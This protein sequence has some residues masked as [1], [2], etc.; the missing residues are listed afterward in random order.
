MRREDPIGAAF[1]NVERLASR[2]RQDWIHLRIRRAT[3]SF[4][5]LWS[6]MIRAPTG[7]ELRFTSLENAENSIGRPNVIFEGVTTRFRTDSRLDRQIVRSMLLGS[8]W[9]RQT[10]EERRA[11]VSQIWHR[12]SRPDDNDLQE[13]I[14]RF[15]GLLEGL[16][17]V[18]GRRAPLVPELLEQSFEADSGVY[19]TSLLPGS[20]GLIR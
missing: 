19:N 4:P 17:V 12:T 8:G 14:M 20:R 11:G 16:V 7:S 15:C 6:V 9:A 3:A 18:N 2:L 5:A 1:R 10:D 13:T